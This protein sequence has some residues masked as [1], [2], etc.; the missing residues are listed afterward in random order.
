MIALNELRILYKNFLKLNFGN[1]LVAL[2]AILKCYIEFF[3]CFIY[4]IQLSRILPE[5]GNIF[6]RRIVH[7]LNVL[8]YD[9]FRKGRYDFPHFE[10][11]QS[12]KVSGCHVEFIEFKA[13]LKKFYGPG[14][15][16]YLCLFKPTVVIELGKIC[17]LLLNR[18]IFSAGRT[19]CRTAYLGA[20]VH[21]LH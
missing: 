10:I 2:Q 7:G 9:P 20:A 18:Y 19:V 11:S 13:L 5:I 21:T 6:L 4:L 15:I 3:Y 8:A 12:Q 17:S 14:K 16:P 1:I